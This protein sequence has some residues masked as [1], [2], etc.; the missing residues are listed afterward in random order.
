MNQSIRTQEQEPVFNS[1]K[2]SRCKIEKSIQEFY[3]NISKKDKLGDCCKICHSIREKEKRKRYKQQQN[4]IITGTKTCSGCK[5]EKSVN[6]F[7]RNKTNKSWL[8]S[9]CKSC[10]NISDRK[11]RISNPLK[12]L[13]LDCKKRCKQMGMKF[14]ITEK[15]LNIPDICPVLGIP[16]EHSIGKGKRTD[17]SPTIDRIDN[18]KDYI[19]GNVII[20][21]WRANRLKSDSTLPELKQL[22]KFYEELNG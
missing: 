3:I 10:S 18:T 16:L 8:H 11:K 17:N 22:V 6:E 4:V 15:D 12:T 9:I 5:V 14:E 13:L 21:S 19:K 20:V 2:C 1:K 7:Y